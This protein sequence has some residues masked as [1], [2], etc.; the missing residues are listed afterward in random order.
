[1]AKRKALLTVYQVASGRAFLAQISV[2]RGLPPM[3]VIRH[4][5][6]STAIRVACTAAGDLGYPETRER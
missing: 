3:V 4:K 1:M 6:R 5:D 2:R